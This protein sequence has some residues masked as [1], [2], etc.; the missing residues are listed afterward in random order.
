M[1][2]DLSLEVEHCKTQH[3]DASSQSHSGL[4]RAFR[5]TAQQLLLQTPVH[6]GQPRQ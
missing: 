6:G 3:I 2:S 4:F 5:I 1:L